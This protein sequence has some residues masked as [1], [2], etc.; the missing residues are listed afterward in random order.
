[1]LPK[2]FSKILIL[3]IV[4]V[5][6]V[7]GV[8]AW[9]YWWLPKEE[10]K[11]P[12]GV[13]K[14]ETADWKTYRNEEY[15]YEIKY[16]PNFY[17]DEC[18]I[19]DTHVSFQELDRWEGSYEWPRLG[20][21]KF[22]SGDFSLLDWLKQRWLLQDIDI[23]TQN[24]YQENLNKILDKREGLS[25]NNYQAIKLS[26]DFSSGNYDI[27]I[28]N[29]TNTIVKATCVSSAEDISKTCNQMLST[30]RFLK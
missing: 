18:E 3:F 26:L 10:G 8:L 13:I 27:F 30:F 22:N 29:G 2:A 4:V 28:Y 20:I 16:P 11:T 1:M 7:G 21:E 14:D 15:G 9:Q 12:E 25:I 24:Y 23:G 19:C 6:L 17:Y 5:L